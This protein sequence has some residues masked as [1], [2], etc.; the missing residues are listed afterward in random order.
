[1]AAIGMTGSLRRGSDPVLNQALLLLAGASVIFG[2]RYSVD[3]PEMFLLPALMAVALW[4][5]MGIVRI[6]AWKRGGTS[7]A[8]ALSAVVVVASCV[9]HGASRNLQSVTAGLDY[10]EDVLRGVPPGG[11]LFVESDDA[12]PVLYATQVLGR[13]P[14]IEIYHR[15]GVLFRDLSKEVTP[16]AGAAPDWSR[17]RIRVEMAFLGRELT[18]NEHRHFWFLGWPGYEPPPAL[19]LEPVGLLWRLSRASSPEAAPELERAY[20]H[21]TSVRLAAERWGG[22]VVGSYAATY[23]LSR[24]ERALF[25]DDLARGE[26]ELE[27]AIRVAGDGSAIPNYVGTVW[28][29]NGYLHRAVRAFRIAVESNPA[30]VASWN[31][32]ARALDLLGDREG[33]AEA[34]RRSR[35]RTPEKSAERDSVRPNGETP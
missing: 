32:L 33:A 5:G 10:A 34:L 19:R 3:D 30:S 21:E 20:R 35:T 28:A 14:D 4:A 6:A 11:T 18:R 13:R 1:L 12:F 26:A 2:L 29:R 25:E 9:H 7:A 15:R 23:P 17:D 16:P 24:G 31:N 22:G 8:V 27:E